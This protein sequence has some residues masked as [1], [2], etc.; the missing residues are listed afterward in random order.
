M[1]T[2]L[3]RSAIA[4]ALAMAPASASLVTLTYGQF[5]G[6]A[7]SGIILSIQGNPTESGCVSF[8]GVTGSVLTAGVCTG[9]SADVLTGSGETQTRTLAQAGVTS[10]ANFG[11]LLNAV[12]PSGDSIIVNDLIVSFY[13]PTGAL[14]YQ[15]SGLNCQNS[16]GGPIVSG[17][18][19][20]ATT[21][22]VILPTGYLAVLDAAQQT[23]AT[24]AGAFSSSLNVVGM[25]A[26]L[27]S[28]AGVKE[29]FFVVN[30][31]NLSPPAIPEPNTRWAVI[32]GFLMVVATRRTAT[33]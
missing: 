13:N 19:T 25:S 9:S 17:P 30:S 11:L 22:V 26:T 31:A 3:L 7:A 27:G 21:G 15:T 16:Q 14:L 18:C 12:E 5:A 33:R 4:I 10:A 29:T 32:L 2:V 1:S 28:S 8:G 24:A 23:A 6:A 20:L